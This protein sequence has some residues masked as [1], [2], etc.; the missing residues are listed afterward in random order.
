M[1]VAF[2]DISPMKIEVTDSRCSK[3]A[4]TTVFEE[5]SSV[6]DQLCLNII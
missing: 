4:I 2:V 5:K 1:N 3:I 6:Y